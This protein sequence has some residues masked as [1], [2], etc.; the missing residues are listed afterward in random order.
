MGCMEGVQAS[1]PALRPRRSIFLA[2]AMNRSCAPSGANMR[3]VLVV[4]VLA[5]G[6]C[7]GD[8][9]EPEPFDALSESSNPSG[10]APRAH[11]ATVPYSFQLN[12]CQG[13]WTRS[14]W[15]GTTGPGE[16]P[17]GWAASLE[18]P[19]IVSVV[20]LSVME[21]ER[22]S[23]GAFERKATL[24]FEIHNKFSVPEA[25][26]SDTQLTSILNSLWVSDP[27]LA[28]YLARTYRLP[29]VHGTFTFGL[30][31]DSIPMAA[32]WTWKGDAT[33]PSEVT[34]HY[35]GGTLNDVMFRERYFWENGRGISYMDVNAT[36]QTHQEITTFTGPNRLATGTMNEP[37][38]N[39][40]GGP[41]YRSVAGHYLVN[42]D[43]T[44]RLREF[45][46]LGCKE[47]LSSS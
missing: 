17:P 4:A 16:A 7:L 39:A 10:T 19:F 21:C 28:D 47:P 3:L 46:D 40:Q 41:E 20:E 45:G 32:T 37:M 26:D 8:N 11:D 9:P 23:W 35:V 6:G 30:Q 13:M 18:D 34:I 36:G 14:Y 42:Q 38:L 33:D 15:P 31:P 5:L 43:G 24:L 25:C 29:V 27:E 22:V 44:G 12:S 2:S 1:I